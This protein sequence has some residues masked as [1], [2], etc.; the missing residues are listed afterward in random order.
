MDKVIVKVARFN[1]L[2]LRS[3]GSDAKRTLVWSTRNGM[4]R[5]TVYTDEN[6]KNEDKTLDY[7]KIIIARFKPADLISFINRWNKVLE[8]GEQDYAEV[9]CLYPRRVNGELTNEK[10]ITAIMRFGIDVNGICYIYVEEKDKPK[11]KFNILNEWHKHRT[12]KSIDYEASAIASKED[13]KAYIQLLTKL[14]EDDFKING[15]VR[16]EYEEKARGNYNPNKYKPQTPATTTVENKVDTT[17]S[18]ADLL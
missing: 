6:V 16:S 7:G 1:G 14:I 4:P 9:E 15:V 10:E 3:S 18:L 13:A 12:K 8:A 17:N 5:A 2:T 11:A